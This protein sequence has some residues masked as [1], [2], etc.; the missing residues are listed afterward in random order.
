MTFAQD[1][2]GRHGDVVAA[3]GSGSAHRASRRGSPLGDLDPSLRDFVEAEDEADADARLAALLEE[4]A[5]PLVRAIAARKLRAYAGSD[6]LAREDVEDVAADAL[7]ALV[8]KLQAL[9]ADPTSTAIES[10]TDYAATVAYNAFAHHLR[11]RHPAR[12]RLKNR[13]RYVLT[14]DR[15]FALWTTPEGLVCGLAEWRSADARGAATDRLDR[16]LAEPD[17]W[18]PWMR[19]NP[20]A[21]DP[22]ATVGS[23]LRAVGGPVDFDRLVGAIAVLS[24]PDA[25]ETMRDTAALSSVPDEMSPPADL[26][27]E[28]RRDTERLWQQIGSL[29][30]RQRVAL[31]LN[32]RDPQGAGMLWVFPLTGVASIRQIARILEIP[33]LEMAELWNRLPLDDLSIAARLR[34]TRQQVINLRSAARKRLTHRLAEGAREGP[35]QPAAG[36]TGVVSASVENEA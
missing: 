11:R 28:R 35:G 27:L 33:D 1:G 30:V 17:R 18:L 22:A 6:T 20:R 13:L 32:L 9:R 34:C 8:S 26:A 14:R 2:P 7:L 25:V 12:S 31:L 16:L 36:N 3:E 21:D 4:R 10:F 23:I 24:P 5:A 29:P 19:A 15:R